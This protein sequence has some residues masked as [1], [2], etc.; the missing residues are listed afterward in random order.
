MLT[1]LAASPA[2]AV[3]TDANTIVVAVGGSATDDGGTNTLAKYDSNDQFN[4]GLIPLVTM[5]K[6]A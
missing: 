1:A 3:D 4:A 5:S 2:R 6:A